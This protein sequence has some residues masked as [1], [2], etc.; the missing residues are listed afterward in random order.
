MAK[1]RENTFE[2]ILSELPKLSDK[3]AKNWSEKANKEAIHPLNITM[4]ADEY[5]IHT[6]GGWLY[7]RGGPTVGHVC[8][9]DF[10]YYQWHV[11]N[12]ISISNPMQCRSNPAL[13]Y[14]VITATAP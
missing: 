7:F 2:K 9:S 11:D 5:S 14:K 4:Y 12:V 3:E 1:N 10:I 13:Y 6:Y 8:A